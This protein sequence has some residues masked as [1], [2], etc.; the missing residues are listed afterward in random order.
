MKIIDYAAALGIV[1]VSMYIMFIGKSLII[2][3]VLALLIWYII[4]SLT[5]K[6]ANV[7]IGK[8]KVPYYLALAIA[9]LIIVIALYLL[10]TLLAQNLT[11]II[12]QA[13][14]YQIKLESLIV[15]TYHTF[16]VQD[17]PTLTQILKNLDLTSILSALAGTLSTLAGYTGMILIYVLFLLMETRS[18]DTKIDAAITDKNRRKEIRDLISRISNDV[19]TY[20]NIKTFV[21]L[22]TAFC[23]YIVMVLIGI[24][25]P[26]LWAILIF[27]L[28][29]IPTIGSIIAVIPPILLTLIQFDS[30]APFAIATISLITI[31]FAIGNILEPKLMGKSLNLSALVIIISLTVWGKLWGIPG[32]FLCVPIMV[33][34]NIVLAKLPRTRS[35]AVMLSSTGKIT[36]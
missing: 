15:K 27:F 13:P 26:F 18:F 35:I 36:T 2:P 20:L 1:V 21:S 11:D 32:M 5:K 30:L 31:Q 6:A 34:I 12:A 4:I 19:S 10:Y 29:Y 25:F 17:V 22:L 16:G 33:I 24:D 7:T 23:S 3:F 8:Y 9:D 14:T 28:N